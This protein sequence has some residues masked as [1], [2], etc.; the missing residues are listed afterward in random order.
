MV[1]PLIPEEALR[2]GR[3]IMD[4]SM[5]HRVTWETF[6]R[7]RNP[8]TGEYET[9]WLAD[10]T[11]EATLLMIGGQNTADVAAARGVKAD[12]TARVKLGR[13]ITAG[14][15]GLFRWTL[16]GVAQQALMT[17]TSGTDQTDRFRG[18]ATVV[19]TDLS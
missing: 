5:R 3:A 13:V 11:D 4:A 18:L 6:L 2:P 19:D 10:E 12:G 14:M 17:V 7:I 8:E 9:A 15:R 16:K 1:G